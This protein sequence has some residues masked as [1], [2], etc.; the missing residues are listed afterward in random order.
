MS[1]YNAA[2]GSIKP[3]PL[4]SDVRC[5]RYVCRHPAP[6]TRTRAPASNKYKG[7]SPSP[8]PRFTSARPV[9]AGTNPTAATR[10]RSS[11]TPYRQP[12]AKGAGKRDAK[13]G[14][15]ANIKLEPLRAP[16]GV[17]EELQ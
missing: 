7:R 4:R 16:P 5:T 8:R 9:R 1:R 11:A 17:L 12:A 14:P 6:L 15:V 13:P 10:R 3:E 2:S